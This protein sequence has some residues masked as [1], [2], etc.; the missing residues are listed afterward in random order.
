VPTRVVWHQEFTPSKNPL[1]AVPREKYTWRT[2][3][4]N[5]MPKSRRKSATS[6]LESIG[7]GSMRTYPRLFVFAIPV[8]VLA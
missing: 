4:S 3:M 8:V 7:R 5:E 6:P 1:Q 2:D